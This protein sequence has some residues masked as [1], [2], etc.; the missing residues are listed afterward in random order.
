MGSFFDLAPFVFMF[1]IPAVT[2]RTFSEERKSGTLELLFTSP[3]SDHSIIL[4][5]YMA[6]TVIIVLSILPTMVYFTTIY[7][8]GNP[9][10]NIDSAGTFGSYIALLLLG[11]AFASVGVFA[12]A[13][14]ESQVVA[15]IVA[16]F[17]C[18]LL[19]YGI[20]AL[21]ALPVWGDYAYNI[22]QFGMM[23]HYASMSKGLIDSRNAVYFVSV[24]AGML[25]CTNFVVGSR[26]W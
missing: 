18:F 26:K 20:G 10:G 12:S 15:F 4:G 11:A 21:S 14:T 19:Y 13:L 7:Y 1:L 25:L 23:H 17:L 24:I 9:L 22:E 6:A 3:V 2:M 16:A 5:K 8:L